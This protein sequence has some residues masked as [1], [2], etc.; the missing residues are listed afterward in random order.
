MDIYQKPLDGFKGLLIY[1]IANLQF[2]SD[3]NNIA[4]ILKREEVNQLSEQNNLNHVLY[5]EFE[6]RKIDLHKIYDLKP[7]RESKN[8]R[9]IFH[10]MFG[11]RFCFPV[12][13]VIEILT[14]DIM[15]IDKLLDLI[16]Y[17]NKDY[18]GSILKYQNREIY[19]PDFGKITKELDKIAGY[20]QPVY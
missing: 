15:F 11:K 19:L 20:A 17:S 8:N 18:I 12:D 16:P 2:C 9:I 4:A 7:K 1:E 13:S 5:Y 14:M 10:E 6:F 3:V